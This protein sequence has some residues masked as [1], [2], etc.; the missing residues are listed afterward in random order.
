MQEGIGNEQIIEG[1]FYAPVI[2]PD[3]EDA[4][5]TESMYDSLSNGNF[6][7]VTSMFGIC[8]EEAINRAACKTELFWH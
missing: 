6:N 5:I 1:F 2:E 4:F 8:S 7:K 3:V